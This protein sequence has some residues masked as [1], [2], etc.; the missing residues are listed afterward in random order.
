MWDKNSKTK[1]NKNNKTKINNYKTK[2][3]LDFQNQ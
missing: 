2:I 1:I 3:N